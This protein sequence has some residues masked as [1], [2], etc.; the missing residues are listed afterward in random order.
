MHRE[1]LR[2]CIVGW[3]SQCGFYIKN[4]IYPELELIRITQKYFSQ[5]L[6]YFI[7][8]YVLPVLV[9]SDW[10][11]LK[12]KKVILCHSNPHAA[13]MRERCFNDARA[14]V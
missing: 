3:S 11:V 1:A 9:Y 12:V 7:A 8:Q 10:L 5:L 4:G 6:L 13:V 14:T 2:V